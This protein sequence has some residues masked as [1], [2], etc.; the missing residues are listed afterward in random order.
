MMRHQVYV[1][2][3]GSYSVDNIN[4][5][6]LHLSLGFDRHAT[7]DASHQDLKQHLTMCSDQH[8]ELRSEFQNYLKSAANE[9]MTLNNDVSVTKQ[10]VERKKDETS[11]LQLQIDSM[12][13]MAAAKTLARSQVRI[14]II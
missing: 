10:F 8:D 13:Q 6:G 2:A 11:Q 4:L 7:L 5:K 9:I 12:L 1:K 14:E 3:T